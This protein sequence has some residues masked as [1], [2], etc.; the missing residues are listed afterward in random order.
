MLVYNELDFVK[1]T[2]LLYIDFV[3]LKFKDAI[4]Q[5]TFTSGIFLTNSHLLCK[6]G[7]LLFELTRSICLSSTFSE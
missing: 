1:E 2:S 3:W 4:H 5:E 6:L 7:H